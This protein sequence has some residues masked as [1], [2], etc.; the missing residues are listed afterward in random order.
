MTRLVRLFMAVAVLLGLAGPAVAAAPG[1]GQAAARTQ[2]D[3]P[4]SA[5][6][7]WL[8]GRLVAPC[9]WNQTLDIHDSEL[10]RDL[11]LEVRVRLA[12]GEAAGAI[13]DDFAARF[14]DRVRAV[15]RGKDPRTMVPIAVGIG[16][17]LSA[18]GIV[19][20]L[21]RWLA[22]GEQELAQLAP[23]PTGRDAYDDK[24]DEAL[25]REA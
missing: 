13:E 5:E 6:A 1:K 20:L 3:A 21:R 11:R 16:L 2:A 8:Q 23:A 15:P 25:A 7:T 24:L 19:M 18:A 14:G 17:L 4:S 22:T 9:C 10:A 12:A